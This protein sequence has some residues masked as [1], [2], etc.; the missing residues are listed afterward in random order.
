MRTTPE[1][2]AP[3][4]SLEAVR[5][6]CLCGADAVYIGGE[7]FSARAGADNFTDEEM[8]E[9]VRFC[10][11]HGVSVHLALN[12]LIFDSETYDAV[13][14]ASAAAECGVDAIIIQDLGA[15]RLIKRAVPQ[16]PLHAS[17]QM[18]IHTPEGALEAKELGFSRVVLS[19]ELPLEKIK[20]I[21]SLG[22]ETEIFVHGALCMSVSGQCYISAVIGSRSANRGR[23][24][25]ACRLPFTS[26]GQG[27][28]YALSLKDM[29][30]VDMLPRLAGTGVTSFKIEGRMKRPEYVAAAVSACRAALD[31]KKPDTDTLRA[32]FSRSGFTD[33][34]LLG[35]TGRD[36][37]G[38]RQKDD[39]TAAAGVLPPLR[40]LYRT[41]RGI[42]PI[43]LDITIAD[44]KDTVLTAEC[45]GISVTVTGMP[46]QKAIN[47]PTSP[48]D[49]E[50]QLS[51]LGGTVYTAG[52]IITH[53][54]EGL[55][56][57]VSELNRLRRAAADALDDARAEAARHDYSINE[58]CFEDLTQSEPEKHI[59][60]IHIRSAL[61]LETALRYGEYAVLPVSEC[62]S[63]N[64][65]ADRTIA[66]PPRFIT[67]EKHL[68]YEL[69]R[70]AAAGY[71]RLYCNNIA[72]I[73]M[74]RKLGFIL[75][76][77]YG[78]NITNSYSVCMLRDMGLSDCTA[79]FE[80]K[81]HDISALCDIIPI[82]MIVYGR[83]PLMLVR[84]CPIRQSSG[85]QGCRHRITDRTGREFPVLCSPGK[86]YSE[87]FNCDTLFMC[88]RLDE[89]H[90]VTYFDH[91][92][93]AGSP[94]E[95]EKELEQCREGEKP[96]N[97]TR[98][99]YYRGVI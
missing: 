92:T 26:D 24:A 32:V 34:Y 47:R 79:S 11:L 56:L 67:D 66:A 94:D 20:E 10:H 46:P 45:S 95:L 43:D 3:A 86:E 93:C 61:C 55:M 33:G 64:V 42:F 6:A 71:K 53:I 80:T 60:R 51:R 97:I 41:E 19:R 68:A 9:A 89:I 58:D 2:L 83:L 74:G 76:G 57:P 81:L 59:S 15:A 77:G 31:C 35:S 5:A 8:A 62:S 12:T 99:L 84:C 54:G 96:E 73:R 1:L 22:I 39:V 18:T 28:G 70:L 48:A 23:C 37:F 25:Q 36:M 88:D 13:R 78:L 90:G 4:G 29:S 17:T 85:C 65:Y 16:M 14:A 7:R 52:S 75:S 38:H 50:K 21:A 49:A 44:G 27:E 87:I 69:E 40:E 82:S 63:D 30:Y 72:H 91:L 98:G